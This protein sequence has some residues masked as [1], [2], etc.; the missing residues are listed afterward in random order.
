MRAKT[1]SDSDRPTASAEAGQD[2]SVGHNGES[3]ALAWIHG[4][5][6]IPGDWEITHFATSEAEGRLDFAN[7]HGHQ[8]RLAW[9]PCKRTPDCERIMS[10]F[11]ERYLL[12]ES[13]E[14]VKAF[15]GLR[16]EPAGRFLLGYHTPENPSQAALYREAKRTLL[17]WTFPPCPGESPAKRWRPLLDSFAPNDGPWREW[18]AFGLHFFLP[19]GFALEA[20][21][22]FPANVSLTFENAAGQR[23]A[24]HRWGIPGELLRGTDLAGFYRKVIAADGGRVLSTQPGDYRG[25]AS[26][27]ATIERPGARGVERLYGAAWKGSGRIWHNTEERRLCAFEQS[28]PRKAQ[29]LDEEK[30]FPA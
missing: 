23:C 15:S 20:V 19:R 17:I 21:T 26:V 1:T 30:V 24:C 14:E 2:P 28:G 4:S 22:C 8:A 3:A 18:A 10:A 16:T 5:F 11:Y 12:R 7:R 27:A 29:P 13:R 9:Q 6:R 25:M